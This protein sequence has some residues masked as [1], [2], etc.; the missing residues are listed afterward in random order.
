MSLKKVAQ[1]IITSGTYDS[2]LIEDRSRLIFLNSLII[3]GEAILLVFSISA[4]REMNFI[5][6]IAN[7]SAFTVILFIFIFLRITKKITPTSHSFCI[8]GIHGKNNI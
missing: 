7:F 6:L 4:L 2:L 1:N 5:L 3:I 8:I